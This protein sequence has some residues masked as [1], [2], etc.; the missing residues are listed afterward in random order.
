MVEEVVTCGCILAKGRRRDIN[1]GR[2]PVGAKPETRERD[3]NSGEQ[4]A[5]MRR[6]KRDK[7]STRVRK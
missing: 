3:G 4:A 5:R 6:R 1:G 7:D 2:K